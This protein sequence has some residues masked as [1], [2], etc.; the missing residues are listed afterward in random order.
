MIA[1]CDLPPLRRGAEVIVPAWNCVARVQEHRTDASLLKVER[2]S[3]TSVETEWVVASRQ[4]VVPVRSSPLPDTSNTLHVHTP[5]TSPNTLGRMLSTSSGAAVGDLVFCTPAFGTTLGHSHLQ[6]HCHMCFSKLRG[7]VVQCADCQLARYCNRDC[8]AA[9]VLLHEIQCPMLPR[10]PSIV[11]DKDLLLLV[12]AVLAMEL[13]MQNP[14]VVLELTSYVLDDAEEARQYMATTMAL[15]AMLSSSPSIPAWMTPMHIF[16]V[17][18][19]V[20]FNAHPILVD[21][22]TASLGLGLFPDAAKMINHS[23]APNTFPRFNPTT[24]GL[25]FRAVT[26]LAPHALITYSYLDVFGLALLQP[27]PARQTL[28][29]TT[30]HFECQC[31]RCLDTTRS[32]H[33]ALDVDKCLQDLDAAQT[34]QTWSLVR[35][36]AQDLMH[37][38]TETLQLAPDY[39][40]MYVLRAKLMAAAKHEPESSGVAIDYQKTLDRIQRVCGFI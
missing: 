16:D 28:L 25:E 30:F 34:A 39:P 5:I 2:S 15:H 14:H 13:A 31:C 27:T 20:R 32:T 4:V 22:H 23:C 8:M 26:T 19:A 3:A 12:V 6:T 36:R 10:L 9:H 11:G 37:H 18:R 38:W 29:A 24:H 21:L 35:E 33:A 7:R 40:L 1:A 17:L